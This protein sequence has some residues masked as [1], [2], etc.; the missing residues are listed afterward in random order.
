[1]AVSVS[2][3][4]FLRPSVNEDLLVIIGRYLQSYSGV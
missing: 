4:S 2:W 1:M 3:G